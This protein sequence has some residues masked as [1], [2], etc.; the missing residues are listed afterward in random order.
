MLREPLGTS[1]GQPVVIENRPGAGGNIGIQSVARAAPDGHTLLFCS[2]AFAA[3]PALQPQDRPPLYDPLRDFAPITAAVTSPNAIVAHPSAQIGTLAAMLAR[4]RAEPGK[5]DYSSPGSGTGPH[6]AAE[7]FRRATRIELTHVPFNGAAP[8]MQAVLAG[9]VPLGFAAMPAAQSLV[10]TGGLIGLA[11]TGP[12]RWPDLPGMPTV[13][14]TVL[15]GFQ[16]ETWQ[17]LFAPAGT[18]EPVTARIAGLVTTIVRAASSEGRLRGIGFR[19]LLNT[20]A[21]FAAQLATEVPALAALV[22]EAGIR[23]D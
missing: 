11:T 6:L 10:R 5:L 3:N 19:A 17:A 8:A 22:R 20:P 15:P 18:P 2:S 9:T 13:A 23:A 12:E 21:E 16:S 4:A 14:E 1:L 7:M